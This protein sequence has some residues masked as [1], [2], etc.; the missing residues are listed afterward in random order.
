MRPS[1]ISE[2]VGVWWGSAYLPGEISALPGLH[3]DIVSA[4]VHA[5]VDW[6]GGV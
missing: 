3:L 6:V 4:L 1:A 5:G 2:G